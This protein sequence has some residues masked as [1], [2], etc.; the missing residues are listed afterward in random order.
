MADLKERVRL[1]SLYRLYGELLSGTQKEILSSYLLY[2]LSIGEIAEEKGVS[3]AAAFDA[4]K[5]GEK[6][7][8][9]YEKRLH[10]LETQEKI[11]ALNERYRSTEDLAERRAIAAEL[12]ELTKK[13]RK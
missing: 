9:G 1:V 13:L 11:A 8:E 4:I 7:L 10:S 3:R 12:N 6:K 2:D 5:K